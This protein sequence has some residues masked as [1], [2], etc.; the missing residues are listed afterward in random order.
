MKNLLI[1]HLIPTLLKCI[2]LVIS[3]SGQKMV[4]L[5][6]NIRQY[7]EQKLPLYMV[8][9]YFKK[10]EKIPLTN[11]GKLDV[12]ALPEPNLEDLI[13]EEYVVPT[14]DIEIKLC[15]IYSKLFNISSENKIGKM[16]DFNDIGGNSF[17]AIE[18]CILL[19]KELNIK[20]SIKDILTHSVIS[21]LASFIEEIL[22]QRKKIEGEKIN[23]ISSS[24]STT[25]TA[26]TSIKKDFHN[27]EVVEKRNEKEFPV[28]SQ[29]LGVY[30]DSIK[31]ENS[32]IYNIPMSFK[33][34]KKSKV[35]IQKIK[36]AF[37]KLF[38]EQEILK[39]KYEE[40]E[41]NG[42]TKIY[43]FIDE[44]SILIFEY[45][46]FDDVNSFVRPFKL[47]KSPLIRVG[48]VKDEYLLIDMHHIISDGM[49]MNIVIDKINQYYYE[50]KE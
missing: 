20:L 25:T 46:T 29:Q 3:V 42:E 34:N 31:N 35:N 19:E 27:V 38:N 13:K 37:L 14:T 39:S 8:P 47:S 36:K 18:V 41:I 40:R 24:N 49:S 50:E 15:E 43:G 6:I 32:T 16:H 17:N 2:V 30:I 21:D 9:S 45:Y 48:F 11:N 23:N 44:S 22:T 1:V 10:I 26:A 5:F 12:K 4:K 28:T 33:L 7:L